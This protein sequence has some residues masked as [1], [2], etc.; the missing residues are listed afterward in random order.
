MAKTRL[1]IVQMTY[2]EACRIKIIIHYIYLA[3]CLPYD[4]QKSPAF[5]FS[6]AVYDTICSN[7]QIYAYLKCI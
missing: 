7:N 3:V 6:V 1:I 5:V 4:R 2:F